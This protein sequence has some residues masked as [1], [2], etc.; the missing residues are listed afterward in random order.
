MANKSYAQFMNYLL[1]DIR[2]KFDLIPDD[3]NVVI[4]ESLSLLDKPDSYFP[5]A[6]LL[7]TK[8]KY[9]GWRDQR[10]LDQSFRFSI[11]VHLRR[12][13]DETTE[14]DM[15]TALD[16]GSELMSL[17]YDMHRAKIQGVPICDG[18]IQIGGFPEVFYEYEL[19]PK[20]TTIILLAEAEVQLQ[21]TN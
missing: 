21:D 8:Q 13:Q 5:R 11:G 14:E 12:A 1:T 3:K 18:F 20:I 2:S 17:I 6:E 4:G 10:V 7:I 15:Y 16:L 9:N 19:F